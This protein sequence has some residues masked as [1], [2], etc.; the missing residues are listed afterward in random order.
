MRLRLDALR[1]G[2]A[3]DATA[4]LRPPDRLSVSGPPG[5]RSGEPRL[6][7]V[8]PVAFWAE[9]VHE[10]AG[11]QHV[12]GAPAAPTRLSRGPVR[13]Q[14]VRITLAHRPRL[15]Q[16]ARADVVIQK[17]AVG[18]GHHR[19]RTIRPNL[20]VTRYIDLPGLIARDGEA[21]VLLGLL[22]RPI[23]REH[24]PLPDRTVPGAL[25]KASPV[26]L[27]GQV[28]GKERRVRR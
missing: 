5:V 6:R 21:P 1:R 18:A 22:H 12:V 8:L 24:P 4:E 25:G 14:V 10:S 7:G 27:P 26:G 13:Q 23:L 16:P 11:P 17:P 20:R 2:V 19:P 28:V 15:P 3:A 9:E